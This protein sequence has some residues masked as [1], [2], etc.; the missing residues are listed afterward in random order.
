M[1]EQIQHWHD[2][3]R[4]IRDIERRLLIAQTLLQPG[5]VRSAVS[6]LRQQ[7]EEAQAAADRALEACLG[8]VNEHSG[9]PRRT[10]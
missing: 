1:D 9:L 10:T 8:Q 6:A 2:V 4:A 7:L 5:A 3:E